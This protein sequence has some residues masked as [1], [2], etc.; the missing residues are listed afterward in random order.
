MDENIE[1]TSRKEIINQVLNLRENQ[2]LDSKLKNYDSFIL[3]CEDYLNKTTQVKLRRLFQRIKETL[4]I[5]ATSPGDIVSPF[6]YSNLGPGVNKTKRMYIDKMEEFRKKRDILQNVMEL[7]E[8]ILNKAN[9]NDELAEA[10]YAKIADYYH[11]RTYFKSTML[12]K[13]CTECCGLAESIPEEPYLD[14]LLDDKIYEQMSKAENDNTAYLNYMKRKI[15]RQDAD[16][17]KF[18][19]EAWALQE[20]KREKDKKKLTFYLL[21][22][23][24]PL[25]YC[26]MKM[27]TG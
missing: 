26:I 8:Q 18:K 22:I 2:N 20:Q 6:D 15:V 14:D 7:C 24:I 16:N 12:L 21:I 11:S 10:L 1:T 13:K 23:F 3:S 4:L 9:K 27:I 5:L 25:L 19:S 17:I